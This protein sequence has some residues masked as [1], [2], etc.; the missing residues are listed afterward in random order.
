MFEVTNQPP[1]LEPYN[2][3]ASDTVLRAAVAREDAGWARQ[4]LD[5]ARRQLGKPDTVALGFAANRIPPQL[6]TFDR[7][8]HRARRGRVS[9]GLARAA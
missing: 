8:G 2:L 9:S 4:E 7:F 3:F 6:K 5:R 1:P